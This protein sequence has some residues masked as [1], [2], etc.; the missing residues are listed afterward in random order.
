MS[1]SGH[2]S[3]TSA[4]LDDDSEYSEDDKDGSEYTDGSEYSRSEDDDTDYDDRLEDGEE[5]V[6]EDYSDDEEDSLGG[7]VH[8]KAGKG[9][10]GGEREKLL[11]PL[12]S[13]ADYSPDRWPPMLDFLFV[14]SS[15]VAAVVAA[16]FTLF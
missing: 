14:F 8:R 7:V 2:H 6:D 1:E 12:H 13:K 11:L 3:E 5:A 4:S 16:Y 10:G 9:I 15:F